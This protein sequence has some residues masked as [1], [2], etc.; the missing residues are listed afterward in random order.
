MSEKTTTTNQP[1]KL[2]FFE[3]PPRLIPNAKGEGY[4]TELI[5]V[6]SPD[7][8]VKWNWWHLPDCD[9]LP[10]N[11]PWNFTSLI[12]YGG[13]TERRFWVEN[14]KVYSEERTYKEGEVN[15]INKDE[16]HLVTSVLPRTLTQM[17]CL[18][19]TKGNAWGYLDIDTGLYIPAQ[20]DPDFMERL[21]KLNPFLRPKG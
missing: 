17:T 15:Q 9:R 20:K 19:A 18:E 6:Q 8:T 5:Q 16:F 21:Y 3:L 13:Y 10:H 14:G 7:L 2:S 4:K 12:H 11:H 1:L